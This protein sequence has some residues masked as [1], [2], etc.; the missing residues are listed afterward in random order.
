MSPN[1]SFLVY[2]PEPH[3]WFLTGSNREQTILFFGLLIATLT[4][5][6]IIEHLEA[7]RTWKS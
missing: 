2:P 6:W 4:T 7:R 3:G 5:L 1:Y